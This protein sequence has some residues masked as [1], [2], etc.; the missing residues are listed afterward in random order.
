MN[1]YESLDT[2]HSSEQTQASDAVENVEVTACKAAMEL[3]AEITHGTESHGL[4]T[5]ISQTSDPA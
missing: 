3:P 1:Y 4:R 2:L 5:Q